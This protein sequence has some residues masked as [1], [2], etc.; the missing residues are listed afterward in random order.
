[1][2]FSAAYNSTLVTLAAN[3]KSAGQ[4][5]TLAGQFTTLDDFNKPEIIIGALEEFTAE[6][7]TTISIPPAHIRVYDDDNQLSRD[8]IAGKLDDAVADSPRPELVGR[9]FPSSVV[10]RAIPP[11]A[12][13][14]LP[15]PFAGATWISST[16]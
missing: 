2:N 16:S 1:V 12:P 4:F 15:S 10:F 3:A 5:T 8:L 13:F 9:F 7:M 11:L 14:Q 6:E